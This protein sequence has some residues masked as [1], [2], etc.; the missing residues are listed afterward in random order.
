MANETLKVSVEILNKEAEAISQQINKIESNWNS[1]VRCIEN[2]KSYW[3]GEAGNLHRKMI[4]N[5][6]EDVENVIKKL[7]EHPS[8]L[9]E[10]AGVYAETETKAQE[11][12][13][14]LPV[15]VII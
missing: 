14:A 1:L 2:S 9:Y 13:N 4:S 7:K 8:D 15:D 5:E 11:L 3:E 12:A 6:K 10:M